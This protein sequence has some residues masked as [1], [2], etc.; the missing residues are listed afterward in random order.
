MTA[1]QQERVWST[2]KSRRP[3][4][5]FYKKIDGKYEWQ[6]KRLGRQRCPMLN[7]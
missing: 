2:L 6:C 3:S 1:D 4:G 7:K 5:I